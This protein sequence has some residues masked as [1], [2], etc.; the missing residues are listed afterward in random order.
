MFVYL[1][2]LKNTLTAM[3]YILGICACFFPACPGPLFN[4]Y[5]YILSESK[6][7]NSSVM[8]FSR[9][10]VVQGNFVVGT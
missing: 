1:N 9:V 6:L 7:Y 10:A 4:R 5:E 8:K 2:H 3:I